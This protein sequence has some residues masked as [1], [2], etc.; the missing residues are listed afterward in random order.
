MT[1]KKSLQIFSF[2]SLKTKFA[3]SIALLILLLLTTLGGFLIRTQ[4]NQI[5]T[6]IYQN[7]RSFIELSAAPLI[8]SF[9]TYFLTENNLFFQRDIRQFLSQNPDIRNISVFNFEGTGLYTYLAEAK[10]QTNLTRIQ[11]AWPS[12]LLT[13][14]QVIYIKKDAV[15]EY[16]YVDSN[17]SPL[18]MQ[19]T[20]QSIVNFTYPLTPKYNLLYDITYN[21]LASRVWESTLVTIISL[22]LALV[23][24][25]Y[26]AFV[27]ATK[28]TN[29]ISELSQV[30]NK[31]AQGKLS[32]RAKNQSQDEVGQLAKDVNQMAK[33]LKKATEAKVYQ[34]RVTKELELATSIQKRLLPMFI[35][36]LIGLDVDA[37]VI[38]AEEIGGDVFDVLQAPDGTNFLYVGDVT[39]H[40]V[41][42]GILA[43]V[44][45][46]LLLN[47]LEK[48]DLVDITDRL[49]EIL[50]KKSSPN[51]FITLAIIKH[52][53]KNKLS[54][55]SAGHEQI[56]QYHAKTKQTSML[57]AGG[58]AA[59]LFAG[60]RAKLTE[61]KIDAKPG[62]VL[63]MY[64]DGIP[65]A[66]LNKTDQYGFDR[67]QETLAQACQKHDSAKD[68]KQ[69]IL[70]DVLQSIKGMPQA[71][72]ITLMVIKVT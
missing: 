11:S 70:D 12:V 71:D 28:V 5:K 22:L 61:R 72:D 58:I 64:S 49:N 24:S 60:M 29:P 47:N 39:G 31:I 2:Q 20:S 48:N 7:A 26:F 63:I 42:A 41:P 65:E 9:E 32:F 8:E 36:K 45:N 30:V 53:I 68:I 16:S 56:I 51:L 59:G 3:V 6:Q 18:D 46:A 67:L 19:I 54:Y 17:G 37:Q 23:I 57:E 43:S 34:A 35:P 38:S 1:T 66:W 21:N 25:I 62:D 55:I 27:L 44:S 69:F 4:S 33:D 50:V 40:G 15:G 10:V 13:D 14:G 52:T